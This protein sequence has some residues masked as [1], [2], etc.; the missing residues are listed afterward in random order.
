VFFLFMF[1]FFFPFSPRRDLSLFPVWF[2][3]FLSDFPILFILTSAIFSIKIR[4][5]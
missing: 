2:H 3:V 4:K 5:Q 1:F